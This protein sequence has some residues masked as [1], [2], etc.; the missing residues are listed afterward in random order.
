MR[1]LLY[2]VPALLAL[3]FID[4]RISQDDYAGWNR[5]SIRNTHR[6]WENARDG[7]R[8]RVDKMEIALL[9]SSTSVDWLRPDYA[10]KLLKVDQRKVLDAH[11]NG[12][13]QTCTWSSVRLLLKRGWHFK[14]A[15][16]GTNQFQI[17]ES[18][19]SK[20]ILQHSD[21]L[22]T[23]D[24]PALLALYS[25]AER[26]LLYMGRFL[27]NTLSGAYGD[28]EVPRKG[29][30]RRLF[31]RPPRGRDH[32]WYRDTPPA[33]GPDEV[34]CDYTPAHV[35][36]KLAATEALLDDLGVLADEVFLMLLPD[37]TL[38]SADPEKQAA[39]AAHRAAHQALADARPY[40][41]LLDL[42]QGGA[43]HHGQF[44]DSIHLNGDGVKIQRALFERLMRAGGHAPAVKP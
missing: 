33:R 11:I 10:A 23:E 20:R 4:H 32:L 37:P 2:I 25:H 43:D 28:T 12:C 14:R 30:A 13:H 1:H 38:S 27:G 42:S 31:G 5:N 21:Q 3:W 6:R 24:L 16:F 44:R 15:F 26:P 39:W 40:V 18:P 8:R 17:C 9:G 19:H 22:P 34:Y 41:T 36:Y 35:A 7:V 29:L